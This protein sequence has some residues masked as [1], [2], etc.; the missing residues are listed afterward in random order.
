MALYAFDGTWNSEHDTGI[1]GVNTNVVEFARAYDGRLAVVQKPGEHGEPTVRDDFYEAGPGTR[2]GWL[3]KMLGGAFGVGGHERIK[4]A[5]ASV[6]KHFAEG[7]VTVDIVG[8][9]RGAA[10]ALHFSNVLKGLSFPNQLGQQT[11]VTIRFLGLWDVVA[12]FGLPLDVG[13]VRFSRINVGYTLRLGD[14]VRHC[15]HA[16][17][18]DE[19]RDAFHETRVDNGYQV[20]FRGAHSDIGGGGGNPGLSNITLRWMLRKAATVGLP[21]DSGLA[22]RL[23]IDPAAAT[24]PSSLGPAHEFR[25]LTTRDR[26]HYTVN[27]RDVKNCQNPPAA[28]PVETQADERDRLTV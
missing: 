20:W 28:C 11:P 4:E 2:H 3:G 15:F 24:R 22:D 12:A 25:Q 21:I 9:S 27:P 1:Y 16:V 8:F 14:H 6:G 5:K 23:S 13:P 7:D 10:L 19:R 18:L 26:I 17:A